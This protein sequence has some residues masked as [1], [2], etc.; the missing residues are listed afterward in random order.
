MFLTISGNL[1]CYTSTNG[2]YTSSAVG[3]T[4]VTAQV[5]EQ[6]KV[7]DV[8]S[9]EKVYGVGDEDTHVRAKWNEKMDTLPR[10]VAEAEGPH[11]RYDERVRAK[12]TEDLNAAITE[13]FGE[14]N[15]EMA[16][17]ILEQ[18]RIPYFDEIE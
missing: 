12:L 8:Y 13:F 15:S 5:A 10:L 7:Y 2:G 17:D 6:I 16:I 1:I 18:L 4:V 3:S 11:A 14:G 9:E